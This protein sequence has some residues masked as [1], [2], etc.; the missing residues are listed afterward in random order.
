MI[1]F[2]EDAHG[3]EISVRMNETLE[4]SLPETRTTGFRWV[5]QTSGEPVCSLVSE[6]SQPPVGPPGQPGKHVWQFRVVQRGI[7]TIVLHYRRPWEHAT[8]ATR[9]FEIRV[10]VTD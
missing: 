9:T 3:Q 6:S 7:A 10:H 2:E 1:R 5:A 4:I 8:A